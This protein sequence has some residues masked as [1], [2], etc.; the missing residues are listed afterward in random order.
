MK[1]NP[2]F[3]KL[4]LSD[5]DRA[6]II[7][8]DDIGMCQAS[9]SAFIDLWDFGLISSG[10]V[11][12]PCP[13][14]PAAAQICRQNPAVDMGVHITLNSEWEK[15]RWSPISTR[16]PASGLI[17]Q[18][19]YFHQ[20]QPAVHANAVP[21][22]IKIE[23]NAQVDKALQFGMDITHIDTHMGTV[24]HQNFIESYLHAAISH[25]VPVMIL[26]MDS[27]GYQAMGFDQDTAMM[28]PKLVEQL[29]SMGLPLIDHISSVEV[30]QPEDYFEMAKK[31]FRELKPGLTHF[32]IHPSKD[33]PELHQIL[34]GWKFRVAEY[35]V[36]S[37][38]P[39]R[40]FINDSGIHV[41]GY[42]SLRDLMRQGT[43]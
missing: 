1:P 43:N 34:S 26:R 15:Y 16:D 42:K 39:M 37:S 28:A 25:R 41:I 20:W 11:M 23:I 36:F 29:E 12:V 14:F 3:K 32:I 30:E 40:K 6:V 21:G 9:V 2:I 8:T 5:N 38:E 13:W 10:S 17:D 33:T 4:G 19:G 22:A 18:Q 31:T 27:A 7:H 35:E 24:A